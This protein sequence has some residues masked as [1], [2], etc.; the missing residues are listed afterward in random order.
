MKLVFP[1]LSV[2]IGFVYGFISG[3]FPCIEIFVVII[4]LALFL[5]IMYANFA[6]KKDIM[7]IMGFGLSFLLCYL[8][9]GRQYRIQNL[10]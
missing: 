4:L 5:A 6:V 8:A 9:L 10:D 3:I 7:I 2:F 1:I